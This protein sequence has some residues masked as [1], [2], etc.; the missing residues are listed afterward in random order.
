[1]QKITA[2]QTI[3]IL[4][5]VLISLALLC[6]QGS[7]MNLEEIHLYAICVAAFLPAFCYQLSRLKY[8]ISW[9]IAFSAALLVGGLWYFIIQSIYPASAQILALTVACGSY[10][11]LRME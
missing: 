8:A 4:I 1:M 11:M 5:I 3:A 9:Q 7:T 2:K 10:L 6:P